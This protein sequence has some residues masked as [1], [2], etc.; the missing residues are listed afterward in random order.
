[1]YSFLGWYRVFKEAFISSL[2][3]D[4]LLLYY[5]KLYV[6]SSEG[7]S[8]HRKGHGLGPY[9]NLGMAVFLPIFRGLLLTIVAYTLIPLYLQFFIN[10]ADIGETQI[11]NS[12]LFACILKL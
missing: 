9:D 8:L 3:D 12:G 7:S 4:R 10:T 2:V 6:D 11:M 1:M 5:C